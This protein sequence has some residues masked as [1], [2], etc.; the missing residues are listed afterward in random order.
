MK[1]DIINKIKKIKSD[2]LYITPNIPENKFK[3]IIKQFDIESEKDN[4]LA[5]YDDTIFGSAKQGM[6][7]T[8][9]KFI[10]HEY[11]TFYYNKI[12]S[13]EYLT[14]YI[15]SNGKE[16][17]DKSIKIVTDGNNINF[18]K[19][20]FIAIDM[21]SLALS[22]SEI[23]YQ[24]QG[25]ILRNAEK[26][27]DKKTINSASVNKAVLSSGLNESALN[28]ADNV[29][30]KGKQGHGYAA[31]KINHSHDILT[32]KDAEIIGDDNAKNGADRLVNGQE[33]QTKYYQKA[34]KT[35]D[36]V[37]DKT[38]KNFKYIDKNGQPM[39]IE[40]PLD[41]Y[42]E[43]IRK[44]EK[45]ISK[46]RVPGVSDPRQA[47]DI[48]KKGEFTYQQA[49]NVAKFGT[50]ESIV[51]DASQGVVIGG[52]AMGISV[53]ISFGIAIWNGDDYNEALKT[54]T[55]SGLKVGGIAFAGSIATAQLGR[56]GLE[57]S[58]RGTTD[59]LVKTMG[60]DAYQ[61][62][63][64][65]LGTSSRQLS[66]AAAANHLSKIVRGNTVTAIAATAIL[67]T[68]DVYRLVNGKVS[69]KQVFKNI[70]KTGSSVA[71]G[72]GG[73]MV[74]A[75]AGTTAGAVLGSIVPVIGNAAG[76]TV[77][78]WVGSFIGGFIGGSGVEKVSGA[79]LDSAIDDDSVEMMKIFEKYFLEL[80]Y[81]YLLTDKEAW[82][83][84]NIIQKQG[85]NDILRE[86]YAAENRK[87]HIEKLLIPYIENILIN[88]EEVILPNN[89]EILKEIS[90]ILLEREEV[91]RKQRHDFLFVLHSL[92]WALANID[93]DVATEEVEIF[94]HIFDEMINA[95]DF[96][97]EYLERISYFLSNPPSFDD[98]VDYLHILDSNKYE[99][100]RDILIQVMNAD[101]VEDKK[102]VKF[103]E[104]FDKKMTNLM[105]LKSE[106]YQSSLGFEM[107]MYFE[108]KKLNVGVGKVVNGNFSIGDAVMLKSEDKFYF[109]RIK[110]IKTDNN[111]FKNIEEGEAKL[112]Y[113]ENLPK[114]GISNYKYLLK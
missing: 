9:K 37:F 106:F 67:S 6:V 100:I 113:F 18:L 82:V 72:M 102:E 36:S 107:E 24:L 62:F 58:L 35:I 25:N 81:K 90:N 44:M 56:T 49:I 93:G 77:G 105:Y 101:G 98:I 1:K 97:I 17:K 64:N 66:G 55:Y 114:T 73:A 71:G 86:I 87:K 109:T 23:I 92:S 70:T 43:A 75:T 11:G 88:R 74:G 10:H 65:A 33:I 41:Q 50:I 40:V 32:G 4:I 15:D 112:I 14:S 76:A 5:V 96:P 22:I 57:Q 78:Y 2:Q 80:S 79:I 111:D 7:F 69:G 26:R 3:N 68:A 63:A 30:M 31:E 108:Q 94:N 60:K 42:D 45:K 27:S 13:I 20:G 51:Y 89:E 34:S 84:I 103:I 54:A 38:S 83:I 61:L 19:Y 16:K 53:A 28:Y 21:G 46:G 110:N 39:Q 85:L 91:E 8:D 12:K 59:Y 29:V 47:K 99:E 52:K 95:N 48:V 104:E